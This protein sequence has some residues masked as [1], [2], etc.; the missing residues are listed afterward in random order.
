LDIEKER[1]A[2]K[3]KNRICIK[4]FCPLI[5]CKTGVIDLGHP[6]V[7]PVSQADHLPAGH[8]E[9]PDVSL[10]AELVVFCKKKEL[11]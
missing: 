1:A 7:G 11:N 6:V 2:S 10:V 8:T 9:G 5:T 4:T 3:R